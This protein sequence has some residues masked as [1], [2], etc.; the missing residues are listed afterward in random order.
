MVNNVVEPSQ[1]YAV[2]DKNDNH[3]RFEY[4]PIGRL[5]DC[6]LGCVRCLREFAPY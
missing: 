3:Y 6:V 4:Y 1:Q 5:C 2:D